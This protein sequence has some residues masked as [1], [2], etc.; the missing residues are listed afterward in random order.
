MGRPATHSDQDFI[1]AAAELFASGG[2]RAVTMMAVARS[3]GAPSGSIYHR[4]PDRPALLAA[5]WLRTV[6]R[7]QDAYRGVVGPDP[8]PDNAV[9]ATAWVVDWCRANLPEAMVLQAGSRTFDRENWPDESLAA[10]AD[11][12][13]AMQRTIT[14]TV[15]AV[16]AHTGRP[17]DEVAF[18]VLDLPLAAVRRHLLAGEPPPPKTTRLVRSLAERIMLR[19]PARVP[20]APAR[21]GTEEPVNGGSEGWRS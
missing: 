19:E 6:R 12:D 8:T 21:R 5:L 14:S 10:L 17:S 2:A 20:T 16:A 4:F 13:T 7:F 11:V 3:V 18:A 9:H 1:D 15:R